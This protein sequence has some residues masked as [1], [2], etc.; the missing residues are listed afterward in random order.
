MV[1]LNHQFI[2]I[3]LFQTL[4]NASKEFH[5]AAS[6]SILSILEKNL[7]NTNTFTQTFLQSI[8]VSIDS[9]DPGNNSNIFIYF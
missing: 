7:L 8:L 1:I 4:P 5:I 3:L 6:N 9:K 2:F